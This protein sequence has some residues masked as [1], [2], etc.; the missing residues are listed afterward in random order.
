MVANLIPITLPLP[1]SLPTIEGNVDYR[2][3][4]NRLLHIDQILLQSGLED[5]FITTT[6]ADWL[7][8]RGSKAPSAKAQARFELHCRRALR[9]NLARVLLA[10]E[11]RPFAARLADS[12]LLQYFCGLAEVDRVCVP[13]KSTLQRYAALCPEARV[14]QLVEEL[15]RTAHQKPEQVG[16]P[17]P[18]DL[19]A[20]FVDSCCV[21]ANIHFPVDWVLLRDATRT[22]M[23]AVRLIRD[24]GLKHRMEAP[25]EFLRRMN[26]LCIAMAQ[27]RTKFESKRTRKKILRQ[28][29]RLVGVVRSHAVRYRALL[30]AQW[31][32]TTWT[33]AQAQQVLGR[34]D[35]ILELLP[36]ARKQARQRM[37]QEEPVDNAD[38]LLS[39][40]EVDARVITRR[41]AEAQVEFGNTLLLAENP[42]GL[43][44]DW[45]LFRET[46]PADARL[47]VRSVDRVT[48]VFDQ[49]PKAA[50][51]DRGFDSQQNQAAL[52]ERK[53]YNGLCP[54]SPKELV[55]RN[56]SWKFRKLQQRRAQTEARIAI[57][58]N[59]FLGRP[60]RSKGFDH[61]NVSV[62]WAVL[63]HNLWVLA[64]L[65]QAEVEAHTQAQKEAA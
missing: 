65:R 33:Q 15:L 14:R 12:P 28:I 27:A 30:E 19:E 44:L 13:A 23:K 32:K 59:N 35:H 26:R 42:Q 62:A 54:R 40:Y 1:P 53:I 38:K 24:Q 41:K 47:L 39:L 8:K 61:R 7:A 36:K 64:R 4:R 18:L 20:Y 43:I 9:C 60:L 58:K 52:A 31:Q 11:Y 29:D 16:L 3:F 25:E 37:L 56:K 22:L 55:Q 21:K 6:V 48:A 57:F 10:E 63:T 45:E 5:Q 2:Q 51:T 17:E 50:G 49:P 46:A 34:M